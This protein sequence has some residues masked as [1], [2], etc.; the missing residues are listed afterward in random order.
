MTL[1]LFVGWSSGATLLAMWFSVV[2]GRAA[3]ERHALSLYGCPVQLS[4]PISTVSFRVTHEVS[5]C[6]SCI[7]DSHSR[8]SQRS[9]EAGGIFISLMQV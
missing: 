5:L 9:H 2:T 4:F 8:H 6:K 7:D 3:L 1:S